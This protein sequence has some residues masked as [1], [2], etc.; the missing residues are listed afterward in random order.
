MKKRI[1][2]ILCIFAMI[3]SLTGCMAVVCETNLNADGSGSVSMSIGY[4]AEALNTMKEDGWSGLDDLQDFTYN[5]TVYHGTTESVDFANIDELNNAINNGTPNRMITITKHDNSY[6]FV[7]DNMA[8]V[9]VGE[10]EYNY[11]YEDVDYADMCMVY[12]FHMPYKITQT[13]GSTAGI[14]IANYDLTVD[15]I[16]MMKEPSLVVFQVGDYAQFTDVNSDAWYY[17]AITYA[18][19]VGIINGYGDGKVGPTDQLSFSQLCQIIYN[20]AGASDFY[21]YKGDSTAW[22]APAIAYCVDLGFV[23]KELEPDET[24]TRQAAVSALTRFFTTTTSDSEYLNIAGN[25]PDYDKVAP[26]YRNDIRRAY[27]EKIISGIDSSGTFAP[28]N[29]L[30]RAELSQII[31]NFRSLTKVPVPTIN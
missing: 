20:M 6:T 4:T 10:A 19:S 26:E 22:Y 12:K 21:T 18:Q 9:L 15:L 7:F 14:T 16:A 27:Q 1:L 3:F 13:L 30:S 24:V 28:N 11:G 31:Y 5:G 2:S 8:N 23:I 17:K 29:L 25:I